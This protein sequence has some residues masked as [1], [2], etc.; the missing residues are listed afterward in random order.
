MRK[1]KLLKLLNLEDRVIGSAIALQ[2]KDA[3]EVLELGK[4]LGNLNVLSTSLT[5]RTDT[6]VSHILLI[7]LD[8]K[9]N[10]M[11]GYFGDTGLIE[12]VPPG[13]DS[14]KKKDRV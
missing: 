6:G 3:N 13:D 11:K 7:L 2:L 9:G 1:S 8:K 10:T 4:K 12:I 14:G 5:T